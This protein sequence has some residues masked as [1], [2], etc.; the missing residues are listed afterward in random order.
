MAKFHSNNC[1]AGKQ[2]ERGAR[3]GGEVQ[4]AFASSNCTTQ[5][6]TCQD[7]GKETA[8]RERE[9]EEKEPAEFTRLME[10]LRWHMQ[11]KKNPRFVTGRPLSSVSNTAANPLGDGSFEHIITHKCAPGNRMNVL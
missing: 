5:T 11:K 9:R 8:A 6:T 4:Q 10:M 2:N 7:S 3:R 1:V